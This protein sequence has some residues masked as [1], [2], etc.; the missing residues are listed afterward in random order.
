MTVRGYLCSC[1][2]CGKQRLAP[3]PGRPHLLGRTEKYESIAWLN[4]FLLATALVECWLWE[5]LDAGVVWDRGIELQSHLAQEAP[6][7]GATGVTLS[8]PSESCPPVNSINAKCGSLFFREKR[9]DNSAGRSNMHRKEKEPGVLRRVMG[10]ARL[11]A[12]S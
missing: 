10:W 1:A 11:S 2:H 9:L 8:L 12:V 4:R 5:Q 7:E 3:L 6:P